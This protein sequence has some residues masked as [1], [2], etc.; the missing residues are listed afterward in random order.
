MP[1]GQN[2]GAGLSQG[3][4]VHKG[5]VVS[6]GGWAV[7]RGQGFLIKWFSPGQQ[8]AALGSLVRS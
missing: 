8:S 6:G 5:A 4:L 3:Q 2:L 1:R 7:G